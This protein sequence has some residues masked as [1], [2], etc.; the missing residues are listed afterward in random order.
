M[1]SRTSKVLTLSSGQFLVTLAGLVSAAVLARILSQVEY[2]AYR[3]TLMVYAFA[4]PLLTLGLPKALFYFLPQADRNERGIL[5]GNLLLLL[6][7]GGIFA[8]VLIGGNKWLAERFNNPMLRSLLLIYSPY[9]LAALPVMAIT[10]C[11][12]ALDRVRTLALFNV[13]SK[14]FLVALTVGAALIWRTPHA[15]V[16]GLVL[17]E[18]AVLPI[19]LLLMLGATPN[20]GF[21]PSL[22]N[23]CS[24]IKYCIPLGMAGMLGAISLSLDKMIVSAMCPPEQFAV[25]VNGAMEI[26]LVGILTASVTAVLLPDFV[27]AHATGR[28]E[29]LKT[30]WHRA[31]LKCLLVFLPVMAFVLVMAPELMRVLYSA[32]YE[33]SAYPFRVYCLRLPIRA[34]N[35]GA[36]LMAMGLT[37][38]VTWGAAA[39][40]VLNALLSILFIRMLGPTGAAWAMLVSII[41]LALLYSMVIGGH[42]HLAPSAMLPWRPMARL[43]GATV[44]PT[45][46][47]MAAAYFS[48]LVLRSDLLRLALAGALFLPTLGACYMAAGGLAREELRKYAAYFSM[49]VTSWRRA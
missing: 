30:L 42:L 44:I 12:A 27:R 17:A 16:T 38:M 34:T 40:L 5:T 49:H 20:S 2:A 31:M 3:Q 28:H 9:A 4:S 39:N 36:V 47:V 18:F 46:V 26:P 29:E 41:L 33:A 32:G 35:F 21:L 22:G 13:L 37:R 19:A 45:V 8:L 48:S 1:Q 10:A 14:A 25:Y 23:M 11:L 43:A 24:Q 15:A 7:M 6:A